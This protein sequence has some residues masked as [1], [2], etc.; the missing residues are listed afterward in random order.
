MNVE[1]QTVERLAHLARLNLSEEQIAELQG[2]L[3]QILE[4]IDKLNEIDTENVEP[5][6][7]MSHE[8]NS[9][10]EDDEGVNMDQK[11]ALD[12]APKVKGPFVEV[13]KV[14]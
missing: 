1:R 12:R 14:I 2:D 13:P 6:L 10:R 8:L 7:S 3:A 11:E 5:L 4:W 9:W